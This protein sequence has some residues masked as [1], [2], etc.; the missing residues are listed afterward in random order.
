[1][2]KPVVTVSRLL[3][4]LGF[5]YIF[6]LASLFQGCSPRHPSP[7][8]GKEQ[9]TPPL[10]GRSAPPAAGHSALP[11]SG[12]STLRA[13]GAMRSST[14]VVGKLADAVKLDPA[15]ALEGES[16]VVTQNIFDTLVEYKD[17]STEIQPALATSWRAARDG[18]SWMFTLRKGVLFHD[19]TPCNAE[20]VVFS[21][22][23]QMDPRHPFHAFG[24]FVYWK[25]MWGGY[26]GKIKDVQAVDTYTVKF[27]LQSPVAPFLAN[28][29]MFPF[30]VVSPTAVKQWREDFFK[31]PVGTG[32][33]SF[34]EWRRNE[35]I[36]LQANQSYWRGTP[37]LSRLIFQPIPDNTSRRLQLEQGGVHFMTGINIEDIPLLRKNPRIV[38]AT[39]PGE[40]LAYLAMNVT[41]P[42]LNNVLVRRAVNMAVDREILVKTLY[43]GLGT[44][45]NTPLPPIL[46]GYESSIKGYPHD[47]A[48]ARELLAKAGYPNGFSTSLWYPSTTR[49]YLPQAKAVAEA[50]QANLKEVGIICKLFTFDWGTYLNKTYNGEHEMALLGWVG[51][52]GDPDN[53]LY[54]LLDKD[55]ARKPGSNIA[56]YENNE[57]H[58]LI[59]EA[60]QTLDQSRRA[61]LYKRAQKI[62]AEEAPWVPL[63][64]AHQ[65]VAYRKEVKG[66]IP[67]PTGMLRFHPV[68]LSEP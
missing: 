66:F 34:V 12:S 11:S 32:P 52:N 2:G 18:K 46:W 60:Q 55:N 33:F 7:E 67:H 21:F 45:T 48:R 13:S 59:L 31:H 8:G 28:L 20:A 56:F 6:L 51:D 17:G 36:V 14:L 19:G 38:V 25:T 4:L 63:V 3:F 5:L 37:H 49:E 24:H 41:K 50:I 61:A 54:P 15:D 29:A 47:P 65:K 58:K 23:R 16:A 10:S 22:K 9:V 53:F 35:R 43:Q 44:V 68:S 57:V 42:P 30:A 40:N 1:M 39:K 26:P 62:I 27:L 64:S